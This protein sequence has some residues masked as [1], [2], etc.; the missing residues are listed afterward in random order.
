MEE[1]RAWRDPQA[2]PLRS[3][4]LHLQIT[5]HIETRPRLMCLSFHVEKQ[6]EL[7]SRDLVEK[8][9]R[10]LGRSVGVY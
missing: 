5:Q 7:R 1:D 4:I 10:G 6:E 3:V 9:Q 2:D 8:R